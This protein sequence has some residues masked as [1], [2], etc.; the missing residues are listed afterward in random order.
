VSSCFPKMMNR[1]FDVVRLKVILAKGIHCCLGFALAMEHYYYYNVHLKSVIRKVREVIDNGF[2]R[3]EEEDGF[4]NV[5]W[6]GR[7]LPMMMNHWDDVRVGL[8][9]GIA[10]NRVGHV[11][12]AAAGGVVVK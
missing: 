7:I 11:D 8:A 12:A 5:M 6:V 1:Q 2:Q 10:Q 3:R 4:A 9:N